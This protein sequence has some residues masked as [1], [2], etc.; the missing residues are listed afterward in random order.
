MCRSL[1]SYVTIYYLQVEKTVYLRPTET[2]EVKV[3]C[4]VLY[5]IGEE[6]YHQSV[7]VTLETVEPFTVT[8]R[9][10][11]LKVCRISISSAIA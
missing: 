5:N 2:G 7:T 8:S 1:R 4:K 9:F 10:L 6:Q 11:S 3:T